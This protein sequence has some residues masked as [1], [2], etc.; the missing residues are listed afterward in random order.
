MYVIGTSGHVDHGKSTLV[1]ILTG[2]DP[3]RLY[4]EKIR[5]MTIDLGFSWLKLPNGTEVSIVDVPGHQKF[6]DNM[7]AGISYIDL[8]MLVIAADESV[9]PQ[10]IEHISI[11]KLLQI[12]L[13]IITITK[14]DLVDDNWLELVR[15]DIVDA[16]K[17]TFLEKAPIVEVS[18]YNLNG[19]EL[20]KSKI[21]EE[22]N[23]VEPTVNLN[24]PR[25]FVD[26]SFSMSGFGTVVTGTLVDGEIKIGDEMNFVSNGLSA[27]VRGIQTHKKALQIASPGTRVAI[28]L[29]GISH[30]NI[31]QRGEVLI[32][33]DWISPTIAVDVK[34]YALSTIPRPLKHNMFINFHSGTF[35][36]VGKLRL[37]DSEMLIAGNSVFAQIKFDKHVPLVKGDN[38]IIRSSQLTLGGGQVIEVN[39]SRHKKND[40]NIINRLAVLE[41]GFQ[42]EIVLELIKSNQPIQIQQMKNLTGLANIDNILS[43]LIESKKI[44]HLDGYYFLISWCDYLAEKV[45]KYLLLQ[46]QKYPLRETHSKESLRGNLNLPQ[47]IFNSVITLLTESEIIIEKNGLISLYGY[48]VTATEEQK[49]IT[50]DYIDWLDSNPYSPSNDFEISSELLNK[51]I[52]ENLVVKVSDKI[53]FSSSAYNHMLKEIIRFLEVNKKIT[54]AD[55]RDLFKTSR[56]YALSL[57]DYLDKQHITK[58]V[59]DIRILR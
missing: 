20:L 46:Y 24:R 49:K 27:R 22:L 10:T 41:S 28:N 38:F 58:R 4:E 53:V 42:D 9:M 48:K 17:G 35:E 23:K 6:I 7:V 32:S 43:I 47:D 34:L 29:S 8:A 40:Q 33:G 45:K 51:I 50:Q 59:G 37:L 56:K 2:I 3:D 18:S 11:L 21:E 55:V 44:I 57:M 31:N 16:V 25:V 12:Q 15:G 39:V 30:K 26:R 14:T 13:G 19:I 54:I 5:G 36:V 1:K 52:G